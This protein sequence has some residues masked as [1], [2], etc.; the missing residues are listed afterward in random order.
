MSTTETT[1]EA[2]LH[3]R[4]ERANVEAWRL[5]VMIEAGY[6]HELA[7]KLA[8]VSDVDLHKAVELVESGCHPETAVEILL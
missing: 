7:E 6:P 5:H 4:D 2:P 3:Q 8:P 1:L